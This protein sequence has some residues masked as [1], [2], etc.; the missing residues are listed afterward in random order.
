[1]NVNDE[2]SDTM[3]VQL[4]LLKSNNYSAYMLV[5]LTTGGKASVDATGDF[6]DQFKSLFEMGCA[7]EPVR[8]LVMATAEALR[9]WESAQECKKGTIGGIGKKE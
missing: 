5:T 1:M 8:R 9:G 3:T 7:Y 2:L 4:E 6:S